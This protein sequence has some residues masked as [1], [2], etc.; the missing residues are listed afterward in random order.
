FEQVYHGCSAGLYDEVFNTVYWEKINGREECFITHKLSAWETNLSLIRAFYPKGDLSQLPLVSKKSDQSWLLN[1]AG[2]TILSMGR[3]KEAEEP[4]LTAI[5]IA[6]EVK[7]WENA[8]RGYQNLTTIQSRAGEIDTGLLSAQKAL[9]VAE[10]AK[11]YEHIINSKAYL[12]WVFHLLGNTE[13]AEK[14]FKQ[15]DEL[16]KKIW[17]HRLNSLRG[18][19]YADF[20]I[21]IKR[22][23]E[24]LE[25]TQRN[26]EICER[27]N[28]PADILGCH[29]AISAIERTRGNHKEAY[30]HLHNAFEFA[31]KVGMPFLEIEVL[32]ESGRLHLDTE[33]YQDAIYDANQVLKLCDRTGFL[34]YE[35]DA[36]LI[37]AKA[38]L[39]QNDPEQAKSYANSAYKKATSMHYH[40][41]KVESAQILEK[42]R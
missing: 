2:L 8:S 27:N 11:S 10:K 41:P 30:D 34:L 5:K 15:A 20:L 7:D 40:L 17:G 26:L 19:W 3:L 14:G 42:W 28:W 16:S 38:Y 9:E 18:V 25:I 36:E 12:S 29:R 37:L 1:A 4:S 32:L 21:S 23:D 31:K 24:A 22:T 33:N 35:P 39:A 13:E 6:I